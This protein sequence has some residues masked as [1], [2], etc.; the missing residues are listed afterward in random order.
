MMEEVGR[1]ANPLVEVDLL[2]LGLCI[3]K[4]EC[5][6]GEGPHKCGLLIWSGV[7]LLLQDTMSI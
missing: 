1:P 4:L 2:T 5:L 6:S 3:H 7:G